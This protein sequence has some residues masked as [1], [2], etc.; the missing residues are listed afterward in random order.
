M[1]LF[2]I[3]LFILESCVAPYCNSNCTP[4]DFCKLTISKFYEGAAT[5]KWHQI[6]PKNESEGKVIVDMNKLVKKKLLV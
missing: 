1:Y 2:L 6:D 5:E 4:S 3:V